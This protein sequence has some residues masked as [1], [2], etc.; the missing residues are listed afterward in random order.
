M[1]ITIIIRNFIIFIDF[2]IVRIA[3]CQYY[4]KDFQKF[5]LPYP[6]SLNWVKDLTKMKSREWELLDS[7]FMDKDTSVPLKLKECQRV[8]I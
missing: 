5:H 1:I 8:M 4:Y 6:D 7:N 2:E 3:D